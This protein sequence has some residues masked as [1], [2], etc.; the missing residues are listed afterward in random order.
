[1]KVLI[2]DDF[3]GIGRARFEKVFFDESFNV[4][5]SDAL[6]LDRQLLRLDRGPDTIV[7]HVNYSLK[8]DPKAAPADSPRA[9][10]IDELEYDL[11][12]HRGVW[13]TIP[14]QYADR[15][16][17]AGTIEIIDLP[18]GVRRIVRGEVTVSLFGL[19]RLIE[20]RIVAEI[21]NGYAMT[22]KLT[23]EWLARS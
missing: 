22:T 5:V 14:S 10:F 12:A 16:R 2:E 20:R 6:H 21:E 17:N 8:P 3:P 4:A 19:G 18:H 7:R 1:M 13:R 11:Q 9:G 23:A 15:A